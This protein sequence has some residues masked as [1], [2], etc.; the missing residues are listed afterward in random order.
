MSIDMFRVHFPRTI[1]A[2]LLETLHS[3]QIGQGKKVDE[4]EVALGA[5]LGMDVVTVNSGTA[6]LELALRLLDLKP[7]DEVIT[8]AMSCSATALAIMH[9][10]GTIV[11]ADINPY[12]GLIDP[13]D[14]GRKVSD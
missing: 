1:D 2:P 14:V 7:G 11:W 8:T 10:G 6:A 12:T 3:G 9:A 5:R 4:F 13:I